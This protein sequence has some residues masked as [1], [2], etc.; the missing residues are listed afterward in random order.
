L[1]FSRAALLHDVA[2]FG[3]LATALSL[4]ALPS[5]GV[6]QQEA[7]LVLEARGGYAAPLASFADGARP[8]EGV[9]GGASF[10]VTFLVPGAR[11][12]LYAGFSQH[13]FGCEEAGCAP[14]A[15]LVATGFDVGYRVGL[16]AGPAIP[17]VSLGA[18][19][20]RVETALAGPNA[21]VSD[22]AF[23]L[24]VGAGV[25]L[26]A[27]SPVAVNPGLRLA[28]VNTRLPGGS[29]LRMRYLV[30]E[31]ALALAF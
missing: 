25:Y 14:G 1:P 24:E 22:H 10:G 18:L 17:W 9:G 13:R 12:S 6:A 16:R 28:A 19:T 31:V 26:G 11:W 4:A 27:R 3:C 15:R 5:A 21:G 30:A 2:A 20:T 8:G 29:L 7:P 23:G